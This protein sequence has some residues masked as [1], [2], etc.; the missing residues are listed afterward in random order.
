MK[1]ILFVLPLLM[2]VS[3]LYVVYAQP[4]K[5]A[6]TLNYV[7]QKS[8]RKISNIPFKEGEVLEYLIH[9]GVIDAGTARLELKAEEKT[10][11]GRKILHSVGI[12]K[13][14][15]MFEYLFKIRDRY[16]TYL[17]SEGVFPW[18]FIR[19]VD[20]GGY[21]INQDYKFFQHKNQIDNGKGQLFDT[22]EYLQDMLSA[23]YYART[24]DFSDAK[25]GDVYTI[26]SFVDNK[27]FPLKIKFVGIENV[28]TKTGTY[29]CYKFNPVVQ[30]GRIFKNEHDL[31]VWITNDGN[32]IPILAEANIL[33]GSIKAEIIHY[34]GLSSPIAKVK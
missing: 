4:K 20:E 28:E 13:S 7:E 32:K 31:N 6:E 9:I 29:N 1:K 24:I 16:E 34:E 19:R 27:V 3:V 5:T 25:K 10:I 14:K 2:L 26:N 12:G 18:L 8:L 17:D 23:F 33:F 21:K 22:P 30:S 11:Q 15:G